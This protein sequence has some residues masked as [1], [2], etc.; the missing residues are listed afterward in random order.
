MSALFLLFLVKIELKRDRFFMCTLGSS[1]ANKQTGTFEFHC[2]RVL[3]TLVYEKKS[4]RLFLRSPLL[5]PCLATIFSLCLTFLASIVAGNA[6]WLESQGH[7]TCVCVHTYTTRKYNGI[8]IKR[9]S[10]I[11]LLANCLFS[12]RK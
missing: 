6:L 3:Y 9:I 7:A 11:R 10:V 4:Y 2:R 1:T 8:K 5:H 12:I